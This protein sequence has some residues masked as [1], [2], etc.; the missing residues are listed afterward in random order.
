VYAVTSALVKPFLLLLFTLLAAC[1]ALANPK[2]VRVF[3]DPPT[4]EDVPHVEGSDVYAVTINPPLKP[5]DYAVN[6][7]SPLPPA[8]S[9]WS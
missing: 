3:S 7:V 8:Y 2:P 1:G 5:A 4:P 6:L 9:G